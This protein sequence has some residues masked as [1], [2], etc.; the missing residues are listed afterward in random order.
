MSTGKKILNVFGIIL[1][2]LLSIVLVVLLFVSPVLLSALSTVQPKKMMQTLPSMELPQLLEMLDIEVVDT[3]NEQLMEFI[4]T[5]AVQDI[6]EIYA[7]GVF[8]ALDGGVPEQTLTEE[9]VREIVHNN[10][11]D[12]FA[13]AIKA[14]PELKQLPEAEAKSAAEDMICEA[15]LEITEQL[16]APEEL[17]QEISAQSEV[18]IALEALAQIDMVKLAFIGVLVVL[19]VLIFVCRLFGFRGF[20][21]LSVDLFVASGFSGLVCAGLALGTSVLETLLAENEVIA[22][23]AGN[24]LPRFVQGV[25]IRTGIMLLAAIILL[26]IYLPIKKSIRKKQSG[27]T[28]ALENTCQ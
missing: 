2:W 1:A 18:E 14:S 3:E 12:L 6:F 21:W 19:S 16:P 13:L 27:N 9:T 28:T 26:V 24:I 7:T 4:S 11:D 5:D 17:I 10:L 22:L 15:L 20:R 25:Y 8:S 23:L